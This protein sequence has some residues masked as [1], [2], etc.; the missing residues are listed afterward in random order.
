M[1][2]VMRQFLVNIGD[3]R[4]ISQYTFIMLSDR[5]NVLGKHWFASGVAHYLMYFSG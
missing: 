1:L 5:A 3:S 2:L 4:T